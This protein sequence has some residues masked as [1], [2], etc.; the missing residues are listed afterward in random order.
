MF[1]AFKKK[2]SQNF[3]IS[4]EYIKK[5]NDSVE[6]LCDSKNKIIEIGPGRGAITDGLYNIFKKNLFL[7]EIDR[8]LYQYLQSRYSYIYSNIFHKD[9]LKFEISQ[10]VFDEFDKVNCVGNLPFGVSTPIL[11]HLLDSKNF[12]DKMCFI[13]QKEVAMRLAA[14]PG[15]KAYGIPSIF[16]QAHYEVEYKYE[17]PPEA[18]FPRPKVTSSVVTI[19]KKKEQK[20]IDYDESLFKKIVKE[21]FSKR[22]K[23]IENSLKSLVGPEVIFNYKEMRPEELSVEDFISIT[24]LMKL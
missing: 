11:F 19:S 20:N 18:F 22:R 10:I 3:L 8:D 17:I 5:F 16:F 4:S 2:L 7:V 6:L 13:L 15:N 21:S 1:F 9:F 24:K 12:I 23:K 14:K